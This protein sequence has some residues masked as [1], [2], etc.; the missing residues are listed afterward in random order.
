MLMGRIGYLKSMRSLL[1]LAVKF[2]IFEKHH[3]SEILKKGEIV[4]EKLN[5]GGKIWYRCNHLSMLMRKT[6]NFRMV[7]KVLY[8]SPRKK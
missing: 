4:M 5:L 8:C 6:Y 1:K 2:S 3:W 7:G